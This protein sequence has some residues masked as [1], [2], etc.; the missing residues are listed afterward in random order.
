MA[1]ES[2]ESLEAELIEMTVSEAEGLL[3]GANE[4]RARILL[5]IRAKLAAVSS[6]P[7]QEQIVGV[8][9]VDQPEVL[10]AIGD[11]I[12]LLRLTLDCL[13]ALPPGLRG[14]L[15]KRHHETY[16]QLLVPT[17]GILNITCSTI[18]PEEREQFICRN[19]V[20][21]LRSFFLLLSFF[22]GN[23]AHTF[24]ARN[25]KNAFLELCTPDFSGKLS[26][27]FEKLMERVKEE[28]LG[29]QEG[30]GVDRE[31]ALRRLLPIYLAERQ[32]AF[33]GMKSTPRTK[34]LCDLLHEKRGD[35]LTFLNALLNMEN[36]EGIAE[37]GRLVSDYVF[38]TSASETLQ[39][40]RVVA[41]LMTRSW[42]E[43]SKD[44]NLETY[45]ILPKNREEFFLFLIE[46]VCDVGGIKVEE[47]RAAMEY[48][49]DHC[50]NG[51]WRF[52]KKLIYHKIIESLNSDPFIEE[53]RTEVRRRIAV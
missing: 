39:S 2:D 29:E 50:E 8:L 35:M 42:V 37:A 46:I 14:L 47:R 49:R 3:L 18:D 43:L 12:D 34:Q 40:R 36:M 30:E 11:H 51:E 44:S 31:F 17:E 25:F 5:G 20:S 48:I 22:Y 45:G 38:D 27:D 26:W 6:A 9:E 13:F 7:R 21:V 53:L 16:Y 24:V 41:R 19:Y 32:K 33:R 4:A 52:I 10:L 15:A 28:F 23:T 1:T